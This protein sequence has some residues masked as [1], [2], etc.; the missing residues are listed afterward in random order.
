MTKNRI[1]H[2][3]TGLDTGGAER[4]LYNL[5]AGGLADRLDCAVVSLSDE[6]TMGAPLRAL[7]VPVHVLGMRRGMPGP[8]AVLRLQRL[9]RGFRPDAIQ[10]W[11]YHGNLAATLAARI[12]PGRPA[13]AWNVR[14]SLYDL[15]NEKRL[16]RQVIRANRIFSNR[17]E[18]SIY[19]SQLSR[20]QHEGFGFASA[21]GIVIPN[22][23][24]LTLLRPEPEIGAAVRRE[25]G[26]DPQALVVGHV[27]R[28]HP[29]KDHAGFLR[30][31]VEVARH[32]PAA[33]FLLVGREVTPENP[34]L[35]GI[36]P[37]H[38]LSRFV[39]TG[40][41]RDVAR[42]MQAMDVVCLS[43]AW[44]E[45][46]PNVLGEAM[47]CAMPCVATDVGDSAFILGETGRVVP[48]LDNA[49]LVRA[50]IGTLEQSPEQ[51][52][53]LG[54]E[55]RQRIKALF[56]LDTIVSRYAQL[57]EDLAGGTHRTSL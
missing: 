17:P 53:A 13:L 40:E 47:A 21:R 24:D 33:R 51:R 28:F 26:F 38:L 39:F 57:Y 55:A 19:N 44:G 4:A 9:L 16:T 49:A 35:A 30:A 25:F 52:R 45:A 3:I 29:M 18:A 2:I 7:G 11:M 54:R 48:P 31:A 1:L 23:F 27:A 37:P 8:D 43:S 20:E 42:L 14:H 41:R 56:S 46:F 12:S 34:A 22:G 10:G 36:V 6:G 15:D 5:L 50:L 32:S